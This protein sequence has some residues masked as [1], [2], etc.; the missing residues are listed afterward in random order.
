VT[1]LRISAT[2]SNRLISYR[3]EKLWLERCLGLQPRMAQSHGLKASAV[4][5]RTSVTTVAGI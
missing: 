2:N 3:G 5:L 1:I 4:L